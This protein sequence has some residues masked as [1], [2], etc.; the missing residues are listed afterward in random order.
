MDDSQR[1][2]Q[3]LMKGP[4]FRREYDAIQPRFEMIAF[5]V[6]LCVLSVCICAH[7]ESAKANQ[8]YCY[9]ISVDPDT[10]EKVIMKS[11]SG[12]DSFPIKNIG[13]G[14][15]LEGSGYGK[16]YYATP[17]SE[18]QWD[19]CEIHSNTPIATLADSDIIRVL[20]YW[21]ETVYYVKELDGAPVIIA[22]DR[23]HSAK[24][25][26][27]GGHSEE[28]DFSAEDDEAWA[29]WGIAS[30]QEGTYMD[31]TSTISE[32]GK[33][34]YC[35]C[36]DDLEAIYI[37]TSE[38]ADLYIDKGCN[39]VWLDQNTLLYVG[40]D[41]RLFQYDVTHGTSSTYISDENAAIDMPPLDPF[42]R[43]SMVDGDYLECVHIL[44]KGPRLA[45]LSLKTGELQNVKRVF[46]LHILDT[47]VVIT[48][49]D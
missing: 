8:Y 27:R 17:A 48:W 31:Y 29:D 28:F 1:Y 47:I 36:E 15:L 16:I 44:E 45:L 33:V 20:A 24:Y 30:E 49:N 6:I 32:D 12:G 7:A 46:P 21:D 26:P 23:D 14:Y 38:Q 18:D 37:S 3:E 40:S 39:P 13:Q 42:E 19:I 41:S 10:D 22:L 25:Y 34:A 9:W 43:M 5:I 2:K 35:A 4:K 11:I